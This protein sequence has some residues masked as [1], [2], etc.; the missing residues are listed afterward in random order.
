MVDAGTSPLDV[1]PEFAYV[2]GS[3]SG[4]LAT[5]PRRRR[6]SATARRI[7]TFSRLGVL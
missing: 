4:A 3:S 1:G 2:T 7:S 6:V 5:A